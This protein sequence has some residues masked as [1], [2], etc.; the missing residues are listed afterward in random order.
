VCGDALE[1]DTWLMS[2][3]VLKRQVE[4]FVLNE[5]V[6]LAQAN[7]C[8]RLEGVYLPT[9]KNEMVCDFYPRMGFRLLC[10]RQGARIFELDLNKAQ[11][12][13]T[14]IK[15]AKRSCKELN[16]QSTQN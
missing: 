10:E 16:S 12:F 8:S 7:G 9:P 14:H 5:L 11:P 15:T 4:E 2:C 3:R 1:I 6:M 13:L